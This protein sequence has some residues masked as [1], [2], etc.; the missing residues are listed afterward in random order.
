MIP[1]VYV[2]TSVIG[3]CHDEEFRLWSNALMQDFQFGRFIPVISDIV[4]AE[5]APAPLVVRRTF[6][7]LRTFNAQVVMADEE[8]LA[9]AE[10]YEA[11]SILP[12][13]FRGDMLHI[14]TATVVRVDLLVSWNFKHIVHYDKVRLF[15]A[16]NIESGYPPLTIYSPREVATYESSDTE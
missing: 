5:I 13:R 16:A 9:L 7:E 6:E 15:T 4:E 8:A 10:R 2:D 12:S 11:R 1:R 3:G 14:A